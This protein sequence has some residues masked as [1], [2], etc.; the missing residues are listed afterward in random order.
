MAAQEAAGHLSGTPLSP[1]PAILLHAGDGPFGNTLG[2][3]A[4]TWGSG[5]GA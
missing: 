4:R 3:A 1:A 5:P 2:P